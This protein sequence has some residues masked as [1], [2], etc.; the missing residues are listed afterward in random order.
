M[1]SQ[2]ILLAYYSDL[3]SIVFNRQQKS[4]S[5]A[6]CYSTDGTTLCRFKHIDSH[7]HT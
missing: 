7:V 1:R 4:S 3:A 2:N 6:D 5:S